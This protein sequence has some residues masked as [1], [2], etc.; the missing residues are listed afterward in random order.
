MTL[1]ERCERCER[2]GDILDDDWPE[3]ICPNC[4]EEIEAEEVEAETIP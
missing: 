2:C 1:I 4:I 3:P